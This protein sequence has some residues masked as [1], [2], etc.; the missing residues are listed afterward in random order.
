VAVEVYHMVGERVTF[1]FDEYDIK[2]GEKVASK[3]A[4]IS[5]GAF[6]CYTGAEVSMLAPSAHVDPARGLSSDTL[7]LVISRL[8]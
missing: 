2:T 3:I 8:Q 7:R 5:G 4:H 1:H 6:G